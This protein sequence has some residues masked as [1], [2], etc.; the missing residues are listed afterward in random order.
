MKEPSI[1]IPPAQSA[2][3]V[4][5]ADRA[6]IENL[7]R[8]LAAAWEAGDGAAYARP[9][10]ED[11]D[12]VTFNG[13]RQHGREAVAASHQA[14]FD[15]HLKGSR[16]VFERLDIRA[17]GSD[18]FIVH[19]F[20]N[21]LLKGQTRAPKSRRSLQTLVAVRTSEGLRFTAFHNTRVFAITPFR[22]LLMMLGL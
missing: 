5:A 17:L 13:E 22:A 9:F 12:Y 2:G 4:S 10:T 20:G 3:A 1:H 18:A 16:L 19:S 15:T 7:L 6:A 21:S 11:C 14:L 8:D